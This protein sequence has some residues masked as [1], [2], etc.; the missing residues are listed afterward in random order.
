MELF[1]KCLIPTVS[2]V[3]AALVAF[4]YVSQRA[5]LFPGAGPG[6]SAGSQWGETVPI[7][8]PDGETLHGLHE[9]AEPG[10]PTVLFFLGNADR[11]DNYA[12]LARA[13]AERGIGL[14]SDILSRLSRIDRFSKRRRV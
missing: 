12:F 5:I 14:L 10:R 7:A 3:Y 9:K 4:M 2:A 6:Q 13:L 8:T 1:S 11:A